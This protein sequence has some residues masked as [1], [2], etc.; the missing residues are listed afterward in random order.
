MRTKLSVHCPILNVFFSPLS[1]P[2]FLP[3]LL[4]AQKGLWK[5]FEILHA[6]LSQKI[7]GFQQTK[8]GDSPF[9]YN[10]HI[11]GGQLGRN[12]SSP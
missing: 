12:V 11:L 8:I 2:L 6:L 10:M 3:G 5:G 4:F 1:L 7:L 9:P